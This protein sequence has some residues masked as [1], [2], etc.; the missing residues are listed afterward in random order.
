M[1]GA[2]EN[3]SIDFAWSWFH[4]EGSSDV[5][6]LGLRSSFDS[7]GKAHEIVDSVYNYYT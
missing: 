6:L 1:A 7:L 5:C 3:G 2:E 4:N